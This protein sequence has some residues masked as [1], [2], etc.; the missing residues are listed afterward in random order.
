[1]PNH[2][3][4][5]DSHL[6]Q[7][8]KF[9]GRKTALIIAISSC[10]FT[11]FS[12][13][14]DSL[15]EEEDV[16]RLDEI[17]VQ[18]TA[19]VRTA[20]NKKVNLGALGDGKILDQP[21]SV[22]VISAAEIA[23]K[24]AIDVSSVFNY[25]AS[26]S[27]S[28]SGRSTQ[29][30]S[31]VLV[32]GL[33]PG[34]LDSYKIDGLA[35][36]N[37]FLDL[38]L[39]HF[40]SIELLK[41]V[42]GFA[43][44]VGVPSGVFNYTTK[45]PT[46]ERTASIDL[47]YKSD[48]IF[49]THLDLGGHFD[50]DNRFGYRLNAIKEKGTSFNEGYVDKASASLTLDAQLT[51]ELK[52]YFNGHVLDYDLDG[53]SGGIIQLAN[54]TDNNTISGKTKTGIRGLYKQSKMQLATAGIDWNFA[55]DWSLETAYR[56]AFFNMINANIVQFVLNNEGDYRT[57]RSFS[58]RKFY[59][60]QLQTNLKGQFNTGH[61][62]HKINIG[63]QYQKIDQDDDRN[64]DSSTVIGFGNLREPNNLTHAYT[65]NPSLY[66]MAEYE[67]KA[68][69]IN[70]TIAFN[71]QWSVLLGG[72]Y[73]D[74]SQN[75]YNTLEQRI[76]DYNG[77]HFTPTAALIFKP[78]EHTTLYTSWVRNAL[79]SGGGS[80]S[81]TIANYG[82]PF[83]P[84]ASKQIEVGIKTEHD[85]WYAN[86]ALYELEKETEYVNSANR[87]V[88]DGIV[89]NR[90]LEIAA[91]YRPTRSFQLD[92]SLALLDAK[93][94][95]AQPSFIGNRLEGAAR[96][97]ATAFA[98]YDIPNV[99]GL[100]VNGGVRHTGKVFSDPANTK[101]FDAYTLADI[102]FSYKTNVKNHPVTFG[103]AIR[104]LFDKQYWVTS[105]ASWLQ[106]GD[107]RDLVLNVKFDF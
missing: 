29:N 79:Q 92:T 9:N 95:Q 33:V 46:D 1:M 74:Y 5:Q 86:A 66:R 23:E 8:G 56:Y 61:L 104:N 60:N 4:P 91:G 35:F 16:I 27:A 32:R 87:L 57:N 99:E 71:D 6:A 31:R 70:D 39:G 18:A 88:Q 77:G 96:L 13:A 11:Q 84:M 63:L 50:Q 14:K 94:I 42:S 67:Q 76:M 89:R 30:G 105:G 106:P 49:S 51:D 45:K 64:Q 53:F 83:P 43:Y 17:V 25:D 44:G 40:D 38:D 65:F 75:N 20:Q 78:R 107:P 68:I 58:E 97:Q 22:N 102:G 34:P 73:T 7:I 26:T 2:L 52:A 100:S 98:R 48:R 59:Y 55:P 37:W 80:I 10:I 85:R 101:P 82:E 12:S 103:G 36:P 24:Q 72:R 3:T 21:F 90:G 81:P 69:T 47:G 41:G 28:N 15:A 54:F 62:T 19:N 93:Y